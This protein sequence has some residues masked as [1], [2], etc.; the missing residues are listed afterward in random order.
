MSDAV[1]RLFLL[2]VPAKH[3]CS[4][5]VVTRETSAVTTTHISIILES[6]TKPE[7]T[8][9][10]IPSSSDTSSLPSRKKSSSRIQGREFFLVGVRAP[11]E[12]ELCMAGDAVN[13]IH[14]FRRLRLLVSRR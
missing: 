7:M 2:A 9:W 6:L 11:S 12:I 14:K 3:R 1:L 10:T 4:F 8:L 5:G 13:S